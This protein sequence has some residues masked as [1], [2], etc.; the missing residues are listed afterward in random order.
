MIPLGLQG[1]GALKV[2]ILDG[3]DGPNEYGQLL[4]SFYRSIFPI[5]IISSVFLTAQIW[6]LQTFYRIS[7]A[8]ESHTFKGLC[9]PLRTNWLVAYCILFL[10]KFFRNTISVSNGLDP[11]ELT[12]RRTTVLE[13]YFTVKA[14]TDL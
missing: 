9:Y 8:I 5:I 3:K 14:S 7:K 6:C 12:L 1:P 2:A 13:V 10:I 11:D 4:L